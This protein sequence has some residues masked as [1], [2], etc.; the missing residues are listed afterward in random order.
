[1][2]KVGDVYAVVYK[3]QVYLNGGEAVIGE[4]GN[5]QLLFASIPM[6]KVEFLNDR[7]NQVT[8]VLFAAGDGR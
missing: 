4:N 1:M 6:E 2:G 3:E 5:G 8:E 7:D